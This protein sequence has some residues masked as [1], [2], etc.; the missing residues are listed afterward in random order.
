MK[1][2]ELSFANIINPCK[3]WHKKLMESL[4]G[5]CC[6]TLLAELLSTASAL[7]V[8]GC[9]CP[10]IIMSKVRKMFFQI[11]NGHLKF[12][13]VI[14]WKLWFWTQKPV[15]TI[16]GATETYSEMCQTSEV[17]LFV[18]KINNFHPLTIFVKLHLWS[19]TRIWIRIGA[20]SWWLEQ[21]THNQDLI[22]VV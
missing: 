7:I 6:Y 1:R 15:T 19:L 12:L 14:P 21:R 8:R 10:L 20:K 4:K 18:K 2:I 9:R 3:I 16:C 22:M 17:E 13:K 5:N 11:C